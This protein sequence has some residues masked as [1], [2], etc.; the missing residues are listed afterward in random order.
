MNKVLILF[1]AL[2][3]FIGM[4]V[5]HLGV[6][7]SP[8]PGYPNPGHP[9]SEIGP[10]TFYGTS[11]DVWSFPGKVGIGTSSPSSYVGLDVR[12]SEPLGNHGQ[13]IT[14]NYLLRDTTGP[15][16]VPGT[17]AGWINHHDGNLIINQMNAVAGKGILFMIPGGLNGTSRMFIRSD[18]NVGIGTTS[19]NQKLEIRG[20]TLNYYDSDDWITTYVGSDGPAI[21]FD[22]GRFLRFGT[23]A[24]ATGGSWS[25]KMRIS[26]DGTLEFAHGVTKEENAGKIG[27]KRWSDALDIV[28]AGTTSHNRKVKIWD[29]LDISGNLNVGGTV[30]GIRV[31]NLFTHDFTMYNSLGTGCG[32]S[33]C[34]MPT[35]L[36]A[37]QLGTVKDAKVVGTLS[38]SSGTWGMSVVVPD[39]TEYTIVPSKTGSGIYY[40]SAS[41][42]ASKIVDGMYYFCLWGS[43]NAKVEWGSLHVRYNW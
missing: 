32:G 41:I 7:A 8:D 22:D 43:G 28:G 13:I 21:I 6:I 10:G 19:P 15:S 29:H 30:N 24:G 27:Y 3:F 37:S 36:P 25:E 38:I 35:Y 17:T 23:W 9:A 40:G 4:I 16:V 26:S 1:S 11:S 34:A 33:C 31:E 42:P 39:G 20:N 2:A 14:D 18:G 12:N 5:S